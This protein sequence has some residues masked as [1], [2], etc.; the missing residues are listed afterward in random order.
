MA[1]DSKM[2]HKAKGVSGFS[3]MAYRET[4]LETAKKER[5]EQNGLYI[6]AERAFVAEHN[7]FWTAKWLI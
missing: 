1:S 3:K 5:T 4:F 7:D 6:V 2:A